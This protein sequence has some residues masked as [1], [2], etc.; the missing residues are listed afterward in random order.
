MLFRVGDKYLN[1]T[2]VQ[3]VFFS[4]NI[5]NYSLEDIPDSKEKLFK[6]QLKIFPVLKMTGSDNV[7]L[8]DFQKNIDM[9]FHIELDSS[10]N[11]VH[12]KMIDQAIRTAKHI[13]R[14]KS[15]EFLALEK[16]SIMEKLSMSL[17]L[18]IR[19]AYD[20]PA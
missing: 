10:S 17:G 15:I 16:Q 20:K 2:C 3:Y 13:A 8:Y 18:P 4:E 14:D 5:D 11:N 1:L 6:C 9:S 12:S 19:S 7:Y